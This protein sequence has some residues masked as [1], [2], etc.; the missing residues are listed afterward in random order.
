MVHTISTQHPIRN[1]VGPHHRP[2][3][4]NRFVSRHGLEPGRNKKGPKDVRRPSGL[5][6]YT[7]PAHRCTWTDRRWCGRSPYFSPPSLVKTVVTAICRG[8]SSWVLGKRTVETYV[9]DESRSFRAICHNCVF[10][11]P[12]ASARND[13]RLTSRQTGVLTSPLPG[14]LAR[15]L[16]L[17]FFA[18]QGVVDLVAAKTGDRTVFTAAI[19]HQCFTTT[20]NHKC[21][22]RTDHFRGYSPGQP[23]SLPVSQQ[24]RPLNSA[25]LSRMGTKRMPLLHCSGATGRKPRWV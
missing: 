15:I 19:N 23:G 12:R 14:Y 16:S 4:L 24:Q 13:S 22:Q 9:H 17:S 20:I 11:I 21:P 6:A 8:L 10:S 5:D 7:L 3:L 25:R 1:F 18:D 2:S